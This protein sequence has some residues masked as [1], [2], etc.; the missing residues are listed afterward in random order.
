MSIFSSQLCGL[1]SPLNAC[2]LPKWPIL[3]RDAG[4]SSVA[5][6]WAGDFFSSLSVLLCLDFC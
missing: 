5:P 2:S 1:W 4:L 3:R 6:A